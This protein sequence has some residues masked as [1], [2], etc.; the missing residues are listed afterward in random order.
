MVKKQ[1]AKVTD[2]VGLGAVGH[3]SF[4]P[5]RTGLVLYHKN[6]VPKDVEETNY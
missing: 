3:S 5:V 6:V 2:Q 1:G 4:T